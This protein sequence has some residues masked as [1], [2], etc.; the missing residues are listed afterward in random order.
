MHPVLFSCGA[1]NTT[2]LIPRISLVCANSSPKRVEALKEQMQEYAQREI[3]LQDELVLVRKQ[4][5]TY[6]LSA[7]CQVRTMQE[8]CE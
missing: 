4:V 8:N 5:E 3:E 2:P 7:T 1:K 6:F